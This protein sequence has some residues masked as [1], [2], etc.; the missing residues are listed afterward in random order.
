MALTLGL[1]GTAATPARAQM[2]VPPVAPAYGGYAAPGYYAPR[3]NYSYAAPGY[4]NY[5]RYGATRGYYAA[6]GG[7][8][9]RRGVVPPSGYFPARRGLRRYKPWLSR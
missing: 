8:S 1:A 9:G 5:P 6:N 3:Y 2:M 4:F 7:W